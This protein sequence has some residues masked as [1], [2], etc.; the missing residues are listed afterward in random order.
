MKPGAIGAGRIQ[1]K[2]PPPMPDSLWQLLNY[3]I[4]SIRDVSGINVELLGMREADQPAQLEEA[5]KQSGMVILASV[6]DSLRRYRK[7]QGRIMLYFILNYISDGRLIRIVGDDGAQ[8]V[9]LIHQPGLVEYDVIVDDEA[10]S[11]NQKEKIWATLM[12]M[13]PML[14]QTLDAGDWSILFEY[15][16]LPSSVVEKWQNKIQSQQQQQQPIQEQMQQLQ[17]QVADTKAQL[18]AAQAQLAQAQA[19]KAGSEIGQQQQDGRQEGT[20]DAQYD[21]AADLARTKTQSDTDRLRIA[22]DLQA[23]RERTAADERMARQKNFMDARTR[24]HDTHVRAATQLA[25]AAIDA[26]GDVAA[27][28]IKARAGNRRSEA[29]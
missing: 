16:P 23:K 2:T 8:Y 9:P 27:A 3:A 19:A 29:R 26:R 4:S 1:P 18:Q 24:M 14:G 6:F 22:A 21:Y 5:R 25:D 11:P 17:M 20:A 15:S 12:Q 7:R 28:R 13:M 10:T